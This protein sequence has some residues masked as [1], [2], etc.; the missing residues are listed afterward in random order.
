MVG[1]PGG[2]TVTA[3]WQTVGGVS[4]VVWYARRWSAE[5]AFGPGSQA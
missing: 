3:T 2:T 1:Q 5:A 4:R